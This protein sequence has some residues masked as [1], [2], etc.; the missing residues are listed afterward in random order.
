MAITETKVATAAS[1][2]LRLLS[3]F[4]LRW[5]LLPIMPALVFTLFAVYLPAFISGYRKEPQYNVVD[6]VDVTVKETV[7]DG[8]GASQTNNGEVAV[9]GD[10]DVV[11]EDVT[12]KETISI[13]DRPLNFWKTLLTGAPNPRSLALSLATLLVNGLCVGMVAD[14]LFRDRSYPS[15]D[16]SFVRV[17]Y[18]SENEARLVIREP[19]QSKMPV[20]VEVHLK[21]PHPPFDNPL[22]QDAGGIKWTTNETDYTGVLSIPLRHSKK[23]TYEWRTSNNHSGEFTTPPPVGQAEDTNYGPFTFLSTSCIVP[24]L[25]YNPL[26]HPLSIPGFKHLAKVLPSLNAQFMLFLGDFIY[27]D[28]PRYWDKSVD[29]YREKYRQVYASPDWP[30]VGQNLSWIHVLDDHEI[31]ND[32]SANQTGV[33]HTAVDPYH[34]YQAAANPPPAKK[35]GGFKARAANTTYFEFTQGPAS[36]FLLDTRSYR[37]PNKLPAHEESKTMLGEEQ[38][39]DFL[40]WLRRPEPRGVKWKIV[41]SS[42]PFTKN[43]RVN[44]QDTWGGFLEE[45]AVLL[46]AMWDVANRGIGVVVL[47][48]DR[49]EFAA[50]KFPPPSEKSQETAAVHETAAV[51]EFSVSPLSQFYSPIPTYRQTDDQDVMVKYINKGNSK[52]GAITIENLEG[53]QESSLKYRLYIDGEEVWNTV[54]LSPPVADGG[55]SGSFWDKQL[56]LLDLCRPQHRATEPRHLPGTQ[57]VPLSMMLQ[58]AP[59]HRGFSNSDDR[60]LLIFLLSSNEQILAEF[61]SSVSFVVRSLWDNEIAGAPPVVQYTDVLEK[62]S[63]VAELTSKTLQYGFCIVQDTPHQTPDATQKLLERIAF[64]RETH[65]GGFYDFEPDLAKA[66]TAYTNQAL[67]LHTDTTYFSDPVGVQALHILHHLNE[68]GTPALEGGETVLVD[69]F[70]AASALDEKSYKVLRMIRLPFHASGNEGITIGPDGLYSVLEGEPGESSRGPLWRV[71]WNNTDRGVVPFLTKRKPGETY[72]VQDWYAAAAEYN[73]IVNNPSFQYRFRLQPGQVL[74]FDNWRVLHSRTAFSGSRRVCGGYL[75][76][77][78]FISRFTNTNW[79][80]EEALK[81]VRG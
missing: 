38:L 52:F 17:G 57:W 21:D 4:F 54:I 37:S 75:N 15:Q 74:F 49:H 81:R 8:E 13:K 27:A 3:Y 41:A 36:F 67:P 69:G 59:F 7:V 45:R 18:V 51:W 28:V 33:Y 44:T 14:R 66:D 2:G 11:A 40:A 34:H 25:P 80:R 39:A 30:A 9:N 73:R 19:D 71:R 64:I 48:G 22:W 72:S 16:L 53:G 65:Y 76:R 58:P 10:K 42:V 79:S 61:T 47:S 78:D 60:Y 55:K 46:Q 70:K 68:D 26:D 43:W 35:A 50:T 31:A 20:T 62:E 24:R 32:W 56:S 29:Y 63:G 12:I 1:I 23:R 5:A 77:D 6:E